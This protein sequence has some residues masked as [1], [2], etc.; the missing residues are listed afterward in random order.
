MS[1]TPIALIGC[2]KKKL[3]QASRVQELYQSPLF[4]LSVAY[5]E[6]RG[7]KWAVLSAK[8][9]LVLPYRILEPYDETLIKMPVAKRRAWGLG[10][11]Q[12]LE[13]T[14]GVEMKY[15]FLAGE[16]YRMAVSALPPARLEEPLTGLGIGDRLR[17]LKNFIGEKA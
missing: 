16:A 11:A 6:K 7:L 15:V 4:K 5:A 2:C 12:D 14:W 9:G 3:S 1:E 17:F 10:V 8:H 13:F